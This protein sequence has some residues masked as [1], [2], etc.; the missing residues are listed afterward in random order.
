MSGRKCAQCGL[1]SWPD[2]ETCSRCGT[3]L[4]GEMREDVPVAAVAPRQPQ[5][6][7]SKRRTSFKAQVVRSLLWGLVLHVALGVALM[8][9]AGIYDT[10]TGAPPRQ[11]GGPHNFP[12]NPFI[13]V[14]ILV[15][16]PCFAPLTYLL[17]AGALFLSFERWADRK[18]G[19]TLYSR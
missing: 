12:K 3:P 11:T 4:T 5:Q 8:L 9:L 17:I 16:S 13:L 6:I 7:A 19:D 2:A 15:I 18:F 1:V 10:V 14:A